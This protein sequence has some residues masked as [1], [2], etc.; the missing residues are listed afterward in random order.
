[1]SKISTVTS[2]SN[3]NSPNLELSSAK[4]IASPP[5]NKKIFINNILKLKQKDSLSILKQ[6][7]IITSIMFSFGGLG[8][9]F[10]L[11]FGQHFDVYES[12]NL[13]INNIHK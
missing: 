6:L 11:R 3:L 4:V 9:G 10:A 12:K 2:Q 13:P 7:I 8:F 1:M 5:T